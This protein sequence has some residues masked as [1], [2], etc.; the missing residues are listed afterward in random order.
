MQ[1]EYQTDPS[2][3]CASL[4]IGYCTT[5]NWGN[6]KNIFGYQ[7]RKFKFPLQQDFHIIEIGPIN[8]EEEGQ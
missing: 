6:T 8:H 2:D 5:G 1:M 3:F 4:K 7:G